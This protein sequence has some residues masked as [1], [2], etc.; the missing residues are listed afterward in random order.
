MWTHC[1]ENYWTGCNALIRGWISVDVIP[2]LEGGSD[3]LDRDPPSD[4]ASAPGPPRD[5]PWTLGCFSPAQ[6]GRPVS[7]T[8]KDEESIRF[9]TKIR[10]IKWRSISLEYD[11]LMGMW[12]KSFLRTCILRLG[13]IYLHINALC[14]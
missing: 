9:T 8:V 5:W 4:E 1:N 14:I 13:Y 2:W 11:L 6:I 3:S 10:E 12:F 7:A